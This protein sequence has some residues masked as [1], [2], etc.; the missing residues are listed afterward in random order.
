MDHKSFFLSVTSVWFTGTVLDTSDISTTRGASLAILFTPECLLS[1]LKN[2]F[3]ADWG[4]EP[5]IQGASNLVVKCSGAS[6]QGA[7]QGDI[8]RAARAYL[9]SSQD[10]TIGFP[11]KGLTRFGQGG[12]KELNLGDFRFTVT[13][14]D[15]AFVANLAEYKDGQVVALSN[16]KKKKIEGNK[17]QVLSILQAQSAYQQYQM[18]SCVFPR[19]APP[20]NGHYTADDMC[21]L[22]GV[23]YA[24]E[25]DHTKRIS[26]S[27]AT[28]RKFGRDRKKDFYLNI[29]KDADHAAKDSLLAR[30]VDLSFSQSLSDLELYDVDQTLDAIAAD[31]N[32]PI[33]KS[34]L[35][36]NLAGKIAVIHLD[37]NS[38]GKTLSARNRMAD[39][40]AFSAQMRV[41]QANMLVELLDW[42]VPSSDQASWTQNDLIAPPRLSE[43]TGED[44]PQ[45]L[46][47]ETLLW[48]GDE[49]VFAVPAWRA[50]EIV[51]ILEAALR[52]FEIDWGKGA[53]QKLTH[54]IGLCFADTKTPIRLLSRMASDLADSA[55]GYN[56]DNRK[57]FSFNIGVATV[58][59]ADGDIIKARSKA[60]GGMDVDAQ[61]FVSRLTDE[62]AWPLILRRL[63]SM[64]ADIGASQIASML[65]YAQK[66]QLSQ[67][68]AG[69]V[70]ALK[71]WEDWLDLQLPRIW[72]DAEQ[73][74]IRGHFSDPIFA[75]AD[76]SGAFHAVLWHRYLQGFLPNA[77][78]AWTLR[79][80]AAS[81]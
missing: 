47:V 23:N 21:A 25:K 29:L 43:E 55:K 22:D 6:R 15:E 19:P 33:E 61:T 53:K 81:Q 27:V 37:G 34:D 16:T 10:L 48:G 14:V 63:M 2:Q 75:M 80:K 54:A 70:K 36:V 59:I 38:F 72:G 71:E 74:R 78:G 64:Q 77:T 28:R 45:R 44:L 57:T 35:P 79:E 68:H 51:G 4:F 30:L 5:I 62:V 24:A 20:K 13:A 41:L 60:F 3:G 58:D 8:I 40:Q 52:R 39:R 42:Y 12:R 69:D 26:A 76:R 73:A 9:S 18:P 31:E 46:R 66:C 32:Q 67:L 17:V 11:V 49:M 50:M 56:K 65:D 1:H 7:E